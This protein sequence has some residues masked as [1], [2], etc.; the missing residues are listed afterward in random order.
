MNR[1]FDESLLSLILTH[2]PPCH[3]WLV[4]KLQDIQESKCVKACLNP[5]GETVGDLEIVN[6][7]RRCWTFKGSA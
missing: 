7:F 2:L 4:V 1:K 6:G 5:A 3:W